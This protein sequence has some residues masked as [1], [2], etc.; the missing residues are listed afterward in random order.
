MIKPLRNAPRSLIP[1]LIEDDYYKRIINGL[2]PLF[3]DIKEKLVSEIPRII[4]SYKSEVRQDASYGELLGSIFK[5]IKINYFREFS[6]DKDIK[7]VAEEIQRNNLNQIKRQTKTVL[8]V[9]PIIADTSLD[10][11]TKE[12]VSNNVNLV[13]SIADDFLNQLE[14]MVRS[15]VNRGE[16][17]STLQREILKTFSFKKVEP[18]LASKTGV[19]RINPVKRAK[20]LGLRPRNR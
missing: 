19:R 5:D 2:R 6:P 7:E 15:A 17:A 12:F 3:S 11:T 16:S 10:V 4:T 8:G 1:T 20:L 13:T 18:T 9:E 14:S